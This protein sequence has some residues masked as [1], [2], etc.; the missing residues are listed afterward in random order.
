L[1]EALSFYEKVKI[2]KEEQIKKEKDFANEKP[3]LLGKDFL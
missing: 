3:V 1:D 2:M